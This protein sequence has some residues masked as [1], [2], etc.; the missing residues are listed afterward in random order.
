MAQH[1][2]NFSSGPCILPK[3][4]MQKAAE[5][6]IEYNNSGLSI[7]EMSHR[8]P[9]FEDV[10]AQSFALFRE[11]MNVPDNYD[12][13]FLQGGASLQFTMIPQNLLMGLQNFPIFSLWKHFQ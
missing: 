4:V 11:L 9:E 12:V 2:H 7:I 6:V 8:S 10:M 13:L 1:I 3:E 5:A